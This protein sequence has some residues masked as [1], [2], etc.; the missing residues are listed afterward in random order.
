[1]I[2][3]SNEEFANRLRYYRNLTF[4]PERRFVHAEV[5]WN[6]RF[7]AI[8]AAL[9][10]SQLGRLDQIIWRRREIA[11]RY[12]EALATIDGVHMAPASVEYAQNDYWVVGAVLSPERQGLA[13][14]VAA[15]LFERGV[16]TRPFFYPLHRQ[17]AYLRTSM[18]RVWDLPVADTLG[19]Q[20]LYFPNG[21]GMTD[22]QLDEAVSVTKEVL[23]K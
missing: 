12:R 5:G 14:N 3:T 1:M 9:G 7:S 17:P 21:L 23:G 10:L 20:G 18:A 2:T 22:E 16:Q 13:K 19:E 8:Q 11:R 15:A 6:L 4:S